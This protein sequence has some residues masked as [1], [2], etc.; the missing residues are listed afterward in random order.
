M[1]ALLKLGANPNIC[2][3]VIRGFS[4]ISNIS[5]S[6]DLQKGQTP[7]LLAVRKKNISMAIKLLGAGADPNHMQ[8]VKCKYINIIIIFL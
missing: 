4:L 6:Y 2:T 1:C 7:L 3:Q 8:E 5:T